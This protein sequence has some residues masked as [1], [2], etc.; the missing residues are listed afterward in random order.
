M[1]APRPCSWLA[2]RS[3]AASATCN[4]ARHER[5]DTQADC[6]N[7]AARSSPCGAAWGNVKLAMIWIVQFVTLATATVLCTVIVRYS[8]NR[9]NVITLSCK[10][11]LPCL[12]R[13]AARRLPRLTQ[14]QERT[15]AGV[16][17][18]AVRAARGGSPPGQRTGGFCQLVRAVSR[19]TSCG[20]VCFDRLFRF[21]TRYCLSYDA[22]MAATA[23]PKTP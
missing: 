8:R 23:S 14:R 1:G 3:P 22:A 9:P 18:A 12:P 20:A 15:A 7:V 10:N 19:L 11:R 13:K 6:P 5:R 21:L 16:T 2:R 17:R 4:T